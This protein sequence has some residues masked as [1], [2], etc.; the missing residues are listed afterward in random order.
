MAELGNFFVT[1]GSKFDKAGFDKARAAINKVAIA[2]IAMGGALVAAGLKAA[3]VAGKQEAAELKLATALQT[4]KNATGVSLDTLKAYAS[5]LQS[6][7]TVGDETSLQLMQ[8][9]LTMGISADEIQGATKDT[10]ALSKSLGIDLKASMKMIALAREGDYN[11]LQRYI[12]AL[13]TAT[14]QAEK[15]AIVN[16]TLANGFKL[17][18][19]ERETYLGQVEA[20][21]NQW[22]D[23]IEKVGTGVI[24]IISEV[25]AVISEDV[26]PIMEEWM[27]SVNESGA[28]I[29]WLSNILKGLIQIAI[30]IK[31]AFDLAGQGVA[32]FGLAMTGN[33]KAAKIGFDEL[34]AKTVEYGEALK[35][36]ANIEVRIRERAEKKKSAVIKRQSNKNIQTAIAE[37][38]VKTELIARSLEN[39]SAMLIEYEAW[40][41]EQKALQFEEFMLDLQTRMEM[42]SAFL[43]QAVEVFTNYYA[44]QA[45]KIKNNLTDDLE[46]E[47]VRYN[48]RKKWIEANVVDEQKRNQMLDE[49]AEG[50]QATMSN[51]KSKAESEEKKLQKKMKKFSIAQAIMN[52]AVGVTKALSQTG[53]FGIVMGAMIAAAGAIQIATIKAQKFAHGALATTATPAIFG[54]A[55]PELALPLTHPNTTKLLSNAMATA[56]GGGGGMNIYIT[57]P[58]ITSRRVADE[59]GNRIG[60][61]IMRKVRRNRKI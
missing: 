52:T 30:G 46:S 43:N 9:G 27:D 32:I 1:V 57:V 20:L 50:H 24:P 4:A 28:G 25:V 6:V 18:Q 11:M 41:K 48:D 53:I 13:K 29:T 59:Y 5:Q 55:G 45:Q 40:Q 35:N 37:E 26:L 7:T 42:T 58:P 17:A 39:N 47:D 2:G 33:F 12:P 31:A 34:K 49:L 10:I 8:L 19:S 51:L 56:G 15:E 21:G 14:S 3:Q 54:E 16:A 38:E 22:G 23:F 44:F 60:D 61:S 36:A